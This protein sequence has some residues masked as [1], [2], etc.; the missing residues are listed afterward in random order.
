[1]KKSEDESLTIIN[2]LVNESEKL[3]K[4]TYE[5]LRGWSDTPDFDILLNALKPL[6]TKADDL[7]YNKADIIFPESLSYL[8]NSYEELYGSLAELFMILNKGTRDYGNSK[9][10]IEWMYRVLPQMEIAVNNLK[11]LL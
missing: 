6:K 4:D 11:S 5:V 7:F 10:S 8:D 3:V 9:F 1:M 2:D